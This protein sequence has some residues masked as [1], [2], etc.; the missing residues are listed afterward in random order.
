MLD[1]RNRNKA[2]II[3]TSNEDRKFITNHDAAGGA[4]NKVL[5]NRQT[6][7]FPPLTPLYVASLLEKKGYIVNFIDTNVCKVKTSSIISKI[8]QHKDGL[9]I[10]FGSLTTIRWD[11]KFIKI[12]IKHAYANNVIYANPLAYLFPDI[13]KRIKARTILA[14]D[15]E[16]SIEYFLSSSSKNKIIRKYLSSLEMNLL[17]YP[18]W[19]LVDIKKYSTYTMLTSRGCPIGCPHCPYHVFQADKIKFRSV[20]SVVDEL[21][22]YTKVKGVKYILFRDPCFTFD[23]MRTNNICNYILK[24]KMNFL[25]GCETRVEFLDRR[26]LEKMKKSGC[27]HIRF[28]IESVNKKILK[29]AGRLTILKDQKKYLKQIKDII[30]IC[31]ELNIL[32][33]CFFIVGF[34]DES[35]KTIS[36]TQKF[37]NSISPSAVRIKYLTPYP[38]TKTGEYLRKKGYIKD[39]D[40]SSYGKYQPILKTKYLSIK[41]LT[42]EVN[43]MKSGIMINKKIDLRPWN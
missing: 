23:I 12:I 8:N 36:E 15:I 1:N 26:L 27:H 11:E 31:N 21:K 38:Q 35:S 24:E 42:S 7:I 41:E 34:P 40:L 43:K 2:T 17:P 37:I 4:G 18:S 10:I 6:K 16:S 25:W 22:L 39:F 19:D 9:V 5:R 3:I 14:G 20:A 29:N 30:S 33:I 32:T 13:S 28:G